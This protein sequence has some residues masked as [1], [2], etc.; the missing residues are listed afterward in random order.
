MYIY[1]YNMYIKPSCAKI[2]IQIRPFGQVQL[3]LRCQSRYVVSKVEQL[4]C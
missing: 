4:Q 2:I 1:I 3:F